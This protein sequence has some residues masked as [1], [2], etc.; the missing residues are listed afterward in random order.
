M[1]LPP[2]KNKQA[3]QPTPPD[4]EEGELDWNS[5]IGPGEERQILPEGIATFEILSWKRGR[6]EFGKCGICNCA[7]LKLLVKMADGSASAP[8]EESLPLHTS[9]EWKLYAFFTSI[10]QRKHGDKE[11]FAPNWNAITGA[12]GYC[13]IKHRKFTKRDNTEGTA[14][15]I[16]KFLTYEEAAKLQ[17]QADAS[18]PTTGGS[19]P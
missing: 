3:Q 7:D 14:S 4:T 1:P 15:G 2:P 10:G 13:Q 18:G 9:F 12:E 16:S 17:E 6:R 8:Q 11:R 19:F 5:E